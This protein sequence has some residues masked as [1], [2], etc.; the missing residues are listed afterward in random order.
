MSDLGAVLTA[1]REAI[2]EM[3]VVAERAEANWTTPRA[4]GKWSPQQVVEHVAI[5]HE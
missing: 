4:P 3:L 1:N 5:V 2:D